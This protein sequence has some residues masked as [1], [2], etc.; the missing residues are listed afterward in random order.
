[1]R[2][3]ADGG[4]TQAIVDECRSTLGGTDPSKGVTS[5]PWAEDEGEEEGEEGEEGEQ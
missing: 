2:K 5:D 4:D 1:V 3:A